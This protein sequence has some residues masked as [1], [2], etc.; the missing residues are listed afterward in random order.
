MDDALRENGMGPE[1]RSRRHYFITEPYLK[2][3]S[4]AQLHVA[5]V[6]NQRRLAGYAFLYSCGRSVY[7]IKTTF[8]TKE[9]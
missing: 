5:I 7:P 2:M 4:Y 8:S 6:P 3:L 9:R 1:I